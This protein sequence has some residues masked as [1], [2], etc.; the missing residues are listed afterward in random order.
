M[1][2]VSWHRA[3]RADFE[4]LYDFLW[5]KSPPAAERAAQV[6][7]DG[8]TLLETSPQLGRPAQDGTERR[9]LVL[10][11]GSSAYIVSYILRDNETVII[12]QVWHSRERRPN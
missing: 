1:A 4:R 9:E 5:E 12:L 6:I 8:A 11:F 3:A 7:F 10:S 2:R